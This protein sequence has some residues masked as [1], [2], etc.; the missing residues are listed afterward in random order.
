MDSY[1]TGLFVRE[2]QQMPPVRAFGFALTL[3]AVIIGL[4]L[5]I[6]NIDNIQCSAEDEL[7][8]TLTEDS[9]DH[10]AGDQF[11]IHIDTLSS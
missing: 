1:R 3:T 4:L 9:F 10:E 5:Y 11:C 2:E 8:M 7:P 6:A